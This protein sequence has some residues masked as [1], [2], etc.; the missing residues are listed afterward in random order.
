MQ[1]TRLS[2]HAAIKL[3]DDVR[4][5]RQLAIEWVRAETDRDLGCILRMVTSDVLILRPRAPAIEGRQALED[6]YRQMWSQFDLEHKI[7]TREVRVAGDFAFTWT[8]EEFTLS[9]RNGRQ[10]FHLAGNGMAILRREPDG[11]WRF[12]RAITNALPKTD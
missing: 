6:F 10:V 4:E 3:S 1:D 5:I 8:L 7:S 9:M 12:S 2:G 11:R